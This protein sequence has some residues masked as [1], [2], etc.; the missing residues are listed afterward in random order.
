MRLALFG[1]VWLAAVPAA[2]WR[3]GARRGPVVYHKMAHHGEAEP[4]ESKPAV[5]STTERETATA[6]LAGR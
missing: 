2:W 4:V 3:V 6:E 1:T 5:E